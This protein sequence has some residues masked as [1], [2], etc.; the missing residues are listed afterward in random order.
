MKRLF[1]SLLILVMMLG[2]YPAWLAFKVWQQSNRDENAR[3]DA[4]V[5]LGAAQYDG[6]PSPVLRA[7][8][9][10]AVYLYQEGF[11]PRIVVTG[12]KRIGDRFTESQAS[13]VF[14]AQSGVPPD[15]VLGEDEGR[16]TLESL[17]RVAALAEREGIETLLVVSD[18]LHSER[19]KRIASDLGFEHVRTSPASYLRLERSRATKVREIF[20]EVGSILAYELLDR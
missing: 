15:H 8:L 1:V 12:G 3:S 4:I 5:V 11:A 18:P 10:H 6:N 9:E 14:L 17:E 20:R 13:R 2:A 16:T 7:R 19:A